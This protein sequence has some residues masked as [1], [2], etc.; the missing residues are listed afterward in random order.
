M[1]DSKLPCFHRKKCSYGKQICIYYILHKVLLMGKNNVSMNNCTLFI[2]ND[3][4]LHQQ[5]N[6]H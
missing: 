4:Q 6:Y 5:D 1:V 2:M 3:Y